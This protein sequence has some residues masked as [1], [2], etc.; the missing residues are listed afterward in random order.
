M[1]LILESFEKALIWILHKS[2]SSHIFWV[3]VWGMESLGAPA[4]N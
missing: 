4:Q 2:L 3:V 1:I